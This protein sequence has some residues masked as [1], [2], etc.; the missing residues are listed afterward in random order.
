MLKFNAKSIL[1]V[2]AVTLLATVITISCSKSKDSATAPFLGKW[3]G[4]GCG[5]GT[6]TFTFSTGPTNYSMYLA[7]VVGTD[8]CAQNVTLLGSVSSDAASNFSME[9]QRYVDKCGNNFSLSGGGTIEGDSI[10]VTIYTQSSLNPTPT[11]C[12]F[13]GVK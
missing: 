11:A 6:T 1:L 13:R 5:G 7:Y 3:T 9:T 8:T 4:V 2:V 10:F 12:T